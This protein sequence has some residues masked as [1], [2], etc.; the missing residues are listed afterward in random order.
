[1]VPFNGIFLDKNSKKLPVDLGAAITANFGFGDFIMRDPDTGAEIMRIKSLK[2]LQYKM[3]EIPDKTLYYH[4]RR[5]DISRWLYSRAMFAIAEVIKQHRTRS[6][7][8]V[9]Q[10]RLH[11]LDAIVSYRRMKNRG[12][13]AVFQ[14]DRFDRYSNFARIG[15]GSMGGK[16]RGLAF[17]DSII[18]KY[19]QTDAI[20]GTQVNITIPRTVVICTDL[21]DELG[22]PRRREH[23][24]DREVGAVIGGCIVVTCR[25]DA[26]AGGAVGKH[27]SGNA[28]TRYRVS[29][30]G[31]TGNN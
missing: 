16:G 11:F 2:D 27:D 24:A 9:P 5:N 26:Q 6:L 23:R 28:E 22:I 21:F 8:E 19:P 14:K 1:M 3:M 18:K 13:V 29:R 15:K 30:A 4:A 10:A 17:I 31:G 20:S 7:A 25:A 12:V